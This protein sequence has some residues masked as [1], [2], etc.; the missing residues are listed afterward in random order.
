[1]RRNRRRVLGH[2]RLEGVEFGYLHILVVPTFIT[3]SA[4][5]AVS[6]V[7]AAFRTGSVARVDDHPVGKAHVE[8]LRCAEKLFGQLLSLV[9]AEKVGAPH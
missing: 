4:G 7:G 9:V 5:H 1:M 2:C 8:I 6:N 3:D